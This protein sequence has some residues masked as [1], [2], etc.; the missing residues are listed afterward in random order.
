[1]SELSQKYYSYQSMWNGKAHTNTSS[2]TIDQVCKS[3]VCANFDGSIEA[4][5]FMKERISFVELAFREREEEIKVINTALPNQILDAKLRSTRKANFTGVSVGLV[6]SFEDSIK[7]NN[8]KI[9]ESFKTSVYELNERL[10]RSG[11][12]LNYHNG[13]IQIS[14]D[15]LIEANIEQEF[16][17]VTSDSIW[18]NVDIDMKEALDLRDS[19]GRDPAVY[20]SRALE[21]TIKIISDEKGWTHGRERGAQNYIDNLVSRKNVSFIN[22]WEMNYLK[23]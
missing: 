1:M 3:F 16:W 12:K 4:D 23:S 2:Y 6:G 15:S 17:S 11:Y 21:S 9:N 8:R 19:G 5:L 7:E 20:A 10:R 14:D 13:F 18:R 22:S